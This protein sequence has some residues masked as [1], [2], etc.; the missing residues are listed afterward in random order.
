MKVI[1]RDE[2]KI[3]C[4]MVQQ[5]IGELGFD[6]FLTNWVEG[7]IAPCRNCEFAQKWELP[8]RLLKEMAKTAGEKQLIERLKEPNEEGMQVV[9]IKVCDSL[10]GEGREAIDK[11]LTGQLTAYDL[12]TFLKLY[13]FR[14]T[15]GSVIHFTQEERIKMA[16]E[17]KEVKARVEEAL[18]KGQWDIVRLAYSGEPAKWGWRKRA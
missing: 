7:R 11:W 16:N 5:E 8:V 3:A 15:T 1:L 13:A 2:G 6:E 4:P 10:N 12:G 17:R 18:L 9:V 14:R